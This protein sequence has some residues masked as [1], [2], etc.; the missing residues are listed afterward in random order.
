MKHHRWVDE[1]KDDGGKNSDNNPLATYLDAVHLPA[2]L[3]A[4]SPSC[5]QTC[6]V[7]VLGHGGADMGRQ[8]SR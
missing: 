4:A 7:V 3:I 6:S 5:A 1:D 2:K 8:G